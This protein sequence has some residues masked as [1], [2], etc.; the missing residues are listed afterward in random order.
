MYMESADE[1][2]RYI[3]TSLRIGCTE[4]HDDLLN[5][6]ILPEPYWVFSTPGESHKLLFVQFDVAVLSML[7]NLQYVV[8]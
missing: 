4:T 7:T 6:S 8:S 2:R 3:V 5:P 1:R